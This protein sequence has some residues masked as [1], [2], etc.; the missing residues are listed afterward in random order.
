[1]CALDKA[2]A[3]TKRTRATLLGMGA[4]HQAAAILRAL[5]VSPLPASGSGLVVESNELRA[6]VDE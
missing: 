6:L 5:R 3:Q 1:M 4:T 2:R